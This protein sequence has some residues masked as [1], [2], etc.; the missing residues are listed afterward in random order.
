MVRQSTNKQVHPNYLIGQTGINI[1][2]QVVLDMGFLWSPTTTLDA[3]IDGT[4]EIRDPATNAM[5][6][7]IIRVQSKAT[8]GALARETAQTFA[9]VCDQRDL[10]Y[11]MKGTTPVILICSHTGRREAYWVCIQDYFGRDPE[12]RK[13]RKVIFDKKRDRFD[14]SAAA[15]LRRLVETPRGMDAE[16]HQIQEEG[17]V[18]GRY[19]IVVLGKIG[20][21]KSAL[22]N[23]LVGAPVSDV[24]V[25]RSVTPAGFHRSEF[26]LGG[27][28]ATLFDSWGID[29][30]NHVEWRNELRKEL[31]KRG[32]DKPAEQWFHTIFYCVAAPGARFE[33]FE[34]DNIRSFLDEKYRVAVVLTK[35]ELADEA[36]LKKLRKVILREVGDD[37]PIVEVCAEAKKLKTGKT[38][39][40]GIEELRRVVHA[41]FWDSI[42]AR[43]P[44]RCIRML[45]RIVSRWE[46]EQRQYIIES[47]RIDNSRLIHT[48]IREAQQELIDKLSGEKVDSMVRSEVRRTIALYGAFSAKLELEPLMPRR[49][50]R[51]E[52]IELRPLRELDLLTAIGRRFRALFDEAGVRAEDVDE[53]LGIASDFA[54][55]MRKKI[56]RLRPTVKSWIV[57]ATASL[58]A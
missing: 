49:R 47:T 22:V 56:R 23:Y 50:R 38:K 19:N 12:R 34:A 30:E 58:K 42:T 57:D 37:V 9:F 36:D 51:L 31:G 32:T 29:I 17:N 40:F 15:R 26:E 28:P 53:L 48:M 55:D 24:G 7:E 46:Q 41:G 8:A 27:V 44:D 2:E 13:T 39:T 43:L 35:S 54:D 14:T 52:A 25:G 1:I 33:R 6:H 5:T 45:E 4:I 20:V 18:R 11:W 10:D 21:G 16:I 3:G